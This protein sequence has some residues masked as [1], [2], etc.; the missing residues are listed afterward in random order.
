MNRINQIN[1]CLFLLA[2]SPPSA[3]L[4]PTHFSAMIDPLH[5][6]SALRDAS[7]DFFA[8]VPDS[9]LKQFCAAV[10]D[11]CGDAHT[12][13]RGD[14]PRYL[15]LRQQMGYHYPEGPAEYQYYW[16]DPL[17]KQHEDLD[18]EWNSVKQ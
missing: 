18:L 14:H 6:L 13:W 12:D 16:N 15:L 10:S 7:I 8:G 17:Y 2:F 1:Q 9:L 5:F 3:K 11:T 4:L